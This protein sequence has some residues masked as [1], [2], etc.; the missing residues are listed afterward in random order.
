MGWMLRKKRGESSAPHRGKS[1]VK[2]CMVRRTGRC[3]KG[4]RERKEHQENIERDK[5]EFSCD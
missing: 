4:E 2:Q 5:R 1:T 3:S